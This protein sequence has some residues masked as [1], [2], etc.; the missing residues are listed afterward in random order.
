MVDFLHKA[1]EC[2]GVGCYM[3]RR[4]NVSIDR[5]AYCYTTEMHYAKRVQM[6]DAAQYQLRAGYRGKCLLAEACSTASHWV[7]LT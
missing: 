2:D 5:T 3:L 6:P 4:S 1:M 7:V